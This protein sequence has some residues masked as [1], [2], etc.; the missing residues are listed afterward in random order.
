MLGHPE[1]KINKIE[2]YPDAACLVYNINGMPVESYFGDFVDVD[3]VPQFKKISEF[4]LPSIYGDTSGRLVYCFHP[5]KTVGLD[6]CYLESVGRV[7]YLDTAGK[8]KPFAQIN[9]EIGQKLI[10]DYKRA[11]TK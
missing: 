1:L 8:R 7:P 5:D 9:Q 4:V 11:K 2:S 6:S 3:N 10:A